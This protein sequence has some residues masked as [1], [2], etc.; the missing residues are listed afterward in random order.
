MEVY[1]LTGQK[2]AMND[3]GYKTAGS[4]TITIDGSQLTTGIY[5]YTIS[6]GDNKVTRKMMVD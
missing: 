3:Y 4:H 2:V 5:F 1:T 6:A